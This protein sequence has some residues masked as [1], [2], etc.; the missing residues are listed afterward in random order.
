MNLLAFDDVF[1]SLKKAPIEVFGDDTEKEFFPILKDK[2]PNFE[3][4]W[5][6]LVVLTTYRSYHFTS[7]EKNPCIFQTRE[8]LSKAVCNNYQFGSDRYWMH[9]EETPV[10]TPLYIDTRPEV[11][12]EV[13]AIG[14]THYSIL[15]ELYYAYNHLEEKNTDFFEDFLVHL[16]SIADL[17]DDLVKELACLLKRV[18]GED[19]RIKK[20][21][22][23]E[24]IKKSKE[25]YRQNYDDD[26]EYYFNAGKYKSALKEILTKSDIPE[27]FLK[28]FT[29]R[30]KFKTFIGLIR[31]YRNIIVHRT[32]VLTIEQS[33][34]YFV[35]RIEKIK[36]LNLY[37][38]VKKA[39]LDSNFKKFFINR[40]DI[41]KQLFIEIQENLNRLWE[42]LYQQLHTALNSHNKALLKEFG[43][44]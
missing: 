18:K 1:N 28:S 26:Y 10:H 39:A 25:Y 33:D 7:A 41:A 20:F 2:F 22:E 38:D 30:K 44:E 4:L 6:L 43:F 16:A 9:Q 42:F 34:E 8:S 13:K 32:F 24:F 36:E 27:N 17:V 15:L 11:S 29:E 3:K 12:H 40:S 35:P 5:Q 14:L 37:D 21:S 31:Q 23:D 19:C